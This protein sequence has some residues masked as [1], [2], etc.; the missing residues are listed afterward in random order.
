MDRCRGEN[1]DRAEEFVPDGCDEH[2]HA[3]RI[4]GADAAG[5]GADFATPIDCPALVLLL[6]PLGDLKAQPSLRKEIAGDLLS[7]EIG[8]LEIRW[9]RRRFA[10]LRLGLVGRSG[11]NRIERDPGIERIGPE[12]GREEE[13]AAA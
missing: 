12:H 1:I 8:N 3:N 5:D 6:K 2:R 9:C 10:R 11:K 13:A 7:R 4:V